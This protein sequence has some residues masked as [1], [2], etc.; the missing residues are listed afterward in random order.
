[1]IA[2]CYFFKEKGAV[3]WKYFSKNVWREKCLFSVTFFGQKLGKCWF[4]QTQSSENLWPLFSLAQLVMCYNW[5]L[6]W[7]NSQLVTLIT[8]D[9]YIRGWVYMKTW[10]KLEITYKPPQGSHLFGKRSFVTF[11]PANLDAI[12]NKHTV[13]DLEFKV[14]RIIE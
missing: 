2:R 8:A 12:G 7:P 13:S 1:M 3:M 6:F 11:D 4:P 5:L 14:T 9:P 10:I